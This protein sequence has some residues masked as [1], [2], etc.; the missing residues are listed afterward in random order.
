M[1]SPDCAAALIAAWMLV[2]CLPLGPTVRMARLSRC[3]SGSSHRRV[4]GR[5][6]GAR[7]NKAERA[8]R[9]DIV[10]APR[11]SRSW[12]TLPRVRRLSTRFRVQRKGHAHPEDGSQSETSNEEFRLAPGRTTGTEGTAITRCDVRPR[13]SQPY[14]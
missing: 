11:E 14:S 9:K 2:N 3:S 7:R 8:F 10:N 13:A 6:W 1:V 12:R 4:L 5:G